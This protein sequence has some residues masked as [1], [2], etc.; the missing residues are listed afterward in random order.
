VALSRVT[1]K[2]LRATSVVNINIEKF[3]S[4]LIFVLV[5]VTQSLVANRIYFEELLNK[6][7]IYA[8]DRLRS[9]NIKKFRI[10]LIDKIRT[11]FITK[12]DIV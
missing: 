4:K 7:Y 12:D 5:T 9:V 3:I 2:I 10:V 11:V 1:A 8:E 6:I